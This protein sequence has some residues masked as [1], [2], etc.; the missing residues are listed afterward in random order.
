MPPKK[1]S[2][3]S[4]RLELRRGRTIQNDA[5]HHLDLLSSGHLMLGLDY[6]AA[7]VPCQ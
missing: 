4:V 1:E 7:L 6:S 2:G 3:F 5:P